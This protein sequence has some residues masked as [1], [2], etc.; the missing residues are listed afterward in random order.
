MR[1]QL[2]CRK[3]FNIDDKIQGC[4]DVSPKKTI[5]CYEIRVCFYYVY[6]TLFDKSIFA[7]N[8]K[9]TFLNFVVKF[10]NF[11][12]FKYVLDQQRKALILSFLFQHGDLNIVEASV[13]PT[14]LSNMNNTN[15]NFTIDF[16]VVI[17]N[18]IS[19]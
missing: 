10:K 6:T 8:Y 12:E 9:V 16:V 7:L 4:P 17:V 19:L 11:V 5:V 1:Y 18:L 15:T 3:A 14:I 2:L 13:P